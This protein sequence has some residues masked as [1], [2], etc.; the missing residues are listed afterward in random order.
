MCSSDTGFGLAHECATGAHLSG[1]A[2][3]QER[4]AV[5]DM[6]FGALCDFMH[7]VSPLDVSTF[8]G[9]PRRDSDGTVDSPRAT[10]RRLQRTTRPV[11]VRAQLQLQMCALTHKRRR[12]EQRSTEPL[13]QILDPRLYPASTTT[14]RTKVHASVGMGQPVVPLLLL[15]LFVGRE[16][17]TIPSFWTLAHSSLALQQHHAIVVGIVRR[18]TAL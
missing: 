15:L 14:S 12:P 9:P 11:C 18:S 8:T 7:T 16:Q 1:R 6:S 10:V 4:C 17:C 3:T 13:A 2:A 5:S